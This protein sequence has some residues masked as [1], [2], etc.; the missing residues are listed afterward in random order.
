M[1]NWLKRLFGNNGADDDQGQL[2]L[3]DLASPPSRTEVAVLDL[4]GRGN[5]FG[6]PADT[7]A[8]YNQR[9]RQLALFRPP[10]TLDNAGQSAPDAILSG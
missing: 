6:M 7:G 10:I 1:G 8:L 9:R 2:A 5:E 3:P 4:E